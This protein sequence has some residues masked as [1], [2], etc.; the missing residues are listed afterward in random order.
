MNNYEVKQSAI[1]QMEIDY[2][3]EELTRLKQENIELKQRIDKRKRTTGKKVYSV[4]IKQ[5]ENARVF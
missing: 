4:I 3:R 5:E 1:L 2:L